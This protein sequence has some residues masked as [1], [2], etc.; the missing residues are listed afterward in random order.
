[1]FLKKLL[2]SIALTTC[3]ITS[4]GL[5]AAREPLNNPS[6]NI[7][8][9]NSLNNL[10]QYNNSIIIM[11][12]ELF[13]NIGH[14]FDEH[15][16]SIPRPS[17]INVFAASLLNR[18]FYSYQA[19]IACQETLFIKKGFNSEEY[20]LEEDIQ[21]VEALIKRYDT[22]HHKTNYY[23]KSTPDTTFIS[24]LH[25]ANDTLILESQNGQIIYKNGVLYTGKNTTKNALIAF[26]N[27]FEKNDFSFLRTLIYVNTT[28][29]KTA[30]IESIAQDFHCGALQF[31]C[32]YKK[33]YLPDNF[34]F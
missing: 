20:S 8:Y 16:R 1:M 13:F 15:N 14:S 5:T 27:Y 18:T 30:V 10:T 17:T 9:V 23:K 31:V 7:N 2:L 33:Y 21:E 26:F 24:Q 11:P 12:L 28:P 4:Y 34:Q 22:L 32:P 29:C 3:T 19:V 6:P 25:L